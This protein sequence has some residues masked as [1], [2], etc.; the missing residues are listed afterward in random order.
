MKWL[1]LSVG[2]S[3]DFEKKLQKQ[4]QNF[5]M[6]HDIMWCFNFV[7][8]QAG[9]VAFKLVYVYIYLV[10]LEWNRHIP[11]IQKFIDILFAPDAIIFIV[12]PTFDR[13][14]LPIPY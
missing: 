2:I 1:L 4:E 7:N 9:P 14:K 10:I 8:L 3:R 5:Y 6:N 13:V 11:L 12:M